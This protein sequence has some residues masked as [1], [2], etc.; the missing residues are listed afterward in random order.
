MWR[1]AVTLSELDISG[2]YVAPIAGI[3]LI[4]WVALVVLR[5]LLIGTGVLRFVWHPALFGLGIYVIIVSCLVFA[6]TP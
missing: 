1:C 5:R 6:T 2:L 3:L 4:A